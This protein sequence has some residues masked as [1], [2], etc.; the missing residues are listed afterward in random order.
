MKLSLRK[1]LS[2]GLT[3][4]VITTLGLITGLD[5][6][7]GSRLVIISGIITIAIADAFSDALGIHVSVESENSSTPREIWEATISTFLAKL[8]FALS[9]LVPFIVFSIQLAFWISIVWGMIVLSSVSYQLAREQKL[10]PIK[11]IREHLF[12]AILV[13]TLGHYLGRLIAL[14]LN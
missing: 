7:T 4:A 6:S 5:S 13:L 10:K 1:G 9:F 2:F 3:S 14:Y 12:I 11:V 8:I